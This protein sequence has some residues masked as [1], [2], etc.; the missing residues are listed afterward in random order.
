MDVDHENLL[1]ANAA[2]AE[3]APLAQIASPPLLLSGVPSNVPSKR[4]GSHVI[5]LADEAAEMPTGRE[6]IGSELVAWRGTSERSADRA[7]V[8]FVSSVKSSKTG[9][10]FCRC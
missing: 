7:V 8:S 2:A 5:T 6:T 4:C 1:A 9:C 10:A 3:V